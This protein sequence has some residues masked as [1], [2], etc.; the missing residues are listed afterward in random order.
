M[1]DY[2][3]ISPLPYTSPVV[4]KNGILT[5]QAQSFFETVSNRSLIIGIGSPEG[6]VEASKGAEYMDETG[7]TGTI[8]WIKKF[9]HDGGD[10][11]LGWILL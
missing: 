1:A 2:E 7:T 4:D 9:N 6:A 3:K 11:T 5:Q 10:A 8:K